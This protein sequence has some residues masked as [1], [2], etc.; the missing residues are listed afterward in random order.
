MECK[1]KKQD[2]IRCNKQLNFFRNKKK[3]NCNCFIDKL[4]SSINNFG[5]SLSFKFSN[6]VEKTFSNFN[7]LVS[8]TI[9]VLTRMRH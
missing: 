3:I 8:T 4:Q 1:N 5:H 7:E 6:E 9:N 2:N